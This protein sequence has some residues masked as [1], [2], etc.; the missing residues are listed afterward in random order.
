MCY[1][2]I[3]R[4]CSDVVEDCQKKGL[5]WEKN[6][7]HILERLAHFLRPAL[8]PV[9]LQVWSWTEDNPLVLNEMGTGVNSSAR[10]HNSN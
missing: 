3:K 9:V 10:P 6:L 8:N 4:Q 5:I 7:A 2:D 1:A